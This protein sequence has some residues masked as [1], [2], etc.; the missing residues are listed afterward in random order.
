MKLINNVLIAV[1]VL[2]KGE[3]FPENMIHLSTPGIL[4][5]YRLN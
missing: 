4:C 2:D 3:D 1:G 5:K